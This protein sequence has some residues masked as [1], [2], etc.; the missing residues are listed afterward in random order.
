MVS[1]LL[2]VFNDGSSLRETLVS[3]IRQ[4]Y[5][6]W[7][8]IIVDD[9]STDDTLTLLKKL[10]KKVGAKA[11]ILRNARNMGL[12]RSLILAADH[13]AGQFLARIDVGDRFVPLKLEKQVAFL[14]EHPDYGI[15]GC[16]Y[17]N[18]FLPSHLQKRSD[19]PL[20]DTDIRN[21]ILKKNP[22]AHSCV[23]MR[24]NL[25]RLVGGYDSAIRYSQDYDLWFRFLQVA[26]AA[27]LPDQLCTR[28]MGDTSIS[29]TMR[30]PQM[31]QTVKIQWK[32][33]NKYNPKHYAYLLEPLCFALLPAWLTKAARSLLHRSAANKSHS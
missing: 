25:Y 13:A 32:N 21:T 15:V 18:V 9:G 28:T 27:N 2:S 22:F 16:N 26:K 14:E 12:T 19:L 29:N 10:I 7:E 30:R 3:I 17:L 11:T 23:V 24:T 4:T 1:I 5:P 6:H 8:I 31:W 20:T 33:M